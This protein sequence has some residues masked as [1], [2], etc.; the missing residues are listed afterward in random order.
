M[1]N[2]PWLTSR[3]VLVVDQPPSPL[4]GR[5]SMNGLSSPRR[6]IDSTCGLLVI[7]LAGASLLGA[8]EAFG[9]EPIATVHVWPQFLGPHRN[10]LSDETGLLTQW[11][12]AGPPEVWRVAGGVGM[13]GLVI[14][15]GRVITLVQKEGQQWAL[16]LDAVSGKL[17]WQTPLAPAYRNG[18]G[19]GPRSTPVVAGDFVVVFS[20]EG[21]LTTLKLAD[22]KPAWSHDVVTEF[23]GTVAEYGMACSPLVVGNKVVVTVGLPEAAVVAYD[24]H[25]G[26]LAW[27]SGND[28]AGYSSPAVLTVGDRQQLVAFT[29]A[30]VLGLI[31]ETGTALWR[32][33]YETN[34]NCNIATPLAIEGK[35]FISAGEN[36]GSVLLSLTTSGNQMAVE[37]VWSSQGPKS[38]LR[39]EWQ[40]SIL[41]KGYLY[42]FDN[43]GAAGPVTHLTCIRA[44]TGERVW[45]QLRFGKGNLI[46]ADGKL[47][48]TTVGGEFVM[49]EMSTAGYTEIGRKAVLDSTRQVPA[50]ANG[51]LYL[52]DD[53]EILCLDVRKP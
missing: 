29:G 48:I 18:M 12:A 17:H 27:Q 37:E 39:S 36:H 15:G 20:G 32:Y 25:T 53:R 19:N 5:Q 2:D 49:A 35:I 30:S 45:Q 33:P 40:T 43:V 23:K 26:K 50:L 44:L 11:P 14:S 7:V 3:P 13:S 46:A 42:G 28:P 16:A 4:E 1:L 31:P 47:L 52:R 22:G 9:A 24:L 38:V 6:G 8:K 21:I 51:R 34:F 41:H 10:G